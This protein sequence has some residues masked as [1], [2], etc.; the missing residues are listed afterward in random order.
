M[1]RNKNLYPLSHQHHNGLMAVL[2]LEKGVKKNAEL[3]IMNDFI[4]YCW[5]EELNHHFIAEEEQLNP[6]Q[7]QIPQFQELY[8]RMLSE[9]ILI[10]EIVNAIKQGK[11]S[12][13]QIVSFHTLLEDHIRFEERILFPFLE[14]HATENALAGIG[15]HIGHLTNGNCNNYLVKFWE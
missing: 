1:K 13:E 12:T 2:L 10:R 7:L 11:E 6:E 3:K 9:H 14:E 15:E 4:L 5:N 8:S